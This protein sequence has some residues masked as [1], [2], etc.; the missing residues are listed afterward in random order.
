[1]RMFRSKRCESLLL[2]VASFLRTDDISHADR[3]CESHATADSIAMA[4]RIAD[5]F[6]FS[7][8]LSKLFF[9]GKYF[10]IPVVHS[11][12]LKSYNTFITA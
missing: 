6:R 8:M 2:R 10:D 9:A 5:Y 3:E 12:L 11:G 7:I 1:M 4:Y